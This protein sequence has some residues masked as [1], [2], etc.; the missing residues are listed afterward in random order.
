MKIFSRCKSLVSKAKAEIVAG[1]TGLA[2]AVAVA[3]TVNAAGDGTATMMNVLGQIIPYVGIIGIPIV[4]VGAF[5]LV[6]AFRND[7][8]DAVP[9]AARDIAIGIVLIAFSIIWSAISGALV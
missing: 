2:S 6:M 8:G 1:A 4:A 7:Q 5:K 9:G 3:P